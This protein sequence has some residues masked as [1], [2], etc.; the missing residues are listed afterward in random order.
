M[1]TDAGAA[2]ILDTTVVQEIYELLRCTDDIRKLIIQRP[3]AKVLRD[4]ALDQGMRT[5]REDGW[6]KIADGMT[7]IDESDE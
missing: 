1:G 4:T 3:E 7:T 5:L 6:R 2:G